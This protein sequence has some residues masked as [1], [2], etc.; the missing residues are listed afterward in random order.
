[1]IIYFLPA[2]ILLGLI[3][4]YEDIK[5]G[6]I[7]NKWIVFSLCYTFI[8]YLILISYYY[9]NSMLSLGYLIE[10]LTN[11]IFVVLIGFGFWYFKLW[12]TGDGKLFIAFAAP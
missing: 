8:V 4:S 2:I 9:F 12:T 6:K 5:F 11:F 1:M 10:L 7:R 3:T